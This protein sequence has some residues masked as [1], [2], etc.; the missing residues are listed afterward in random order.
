MIRP[1]A[2]TRRFALLVTGSVV[3]GLGIAAMLRAEVGLDP[4]SL[5]LAGLA[6]WTGVRVAYVSVSLGL[7]LVALWILAFRLRPGPASVVQP[8]VLAATLF[9]ALPLLPTPDALLPRAL[10]AAFGVVAQGTGAGIYLAAS[11]G[12]APADGV[13]IGLSRRLRVPLPRAYLVLQAALFAAGLA[14]ALAA[15]MS[16]TSVVGVGTVAVTLT[17]GRFVA[18]AAGCCERLLPPAARPSLHP[19]PTSA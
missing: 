10:L 15:G 3:L 14:C 7:G 4:Y 6:G 1:V 19:A 8:L 16:A 11:L 9:V 2:L 18:L 17:M 5:L 13:A 12:P